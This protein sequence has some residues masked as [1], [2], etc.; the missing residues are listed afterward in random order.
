[1]VGKRKIIQMIFNEKRRHPCPGLGIRVMGNDL[2]L[3]LFVNLA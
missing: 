3:R 1:M 2:G